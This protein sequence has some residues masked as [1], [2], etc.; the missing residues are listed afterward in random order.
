[1][2]PAYRQNKPAL[3]RDS[4]LE[5]H[6][7]RAAIVGW[8]NRILYIERIASVLSAHLPSISLLDSYYLRLVTGWHRTCGFNS[9]TLSAFLEN[10]GESM[11][12]GAL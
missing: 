11:I 10:K 3:T 7:I 12:E 6:G 8:L 1:M 9:E 4:L 2:S 5:E